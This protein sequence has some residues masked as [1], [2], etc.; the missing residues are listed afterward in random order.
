[1]SSK[2][3]FIVEMVDK[4]TNKQTNKKKT[5]KQTKIQMQQSYHIITYVMRDLFSEKY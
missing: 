3:I 1:M 2:K 5:N 4:Q